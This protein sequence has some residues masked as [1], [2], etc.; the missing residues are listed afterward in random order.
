MSNL[1]KKINVVFEDPRMADFQ[2]KNYESTH[3]ALIHIIEVGKSVHFQAV[4]KHLSFDDA[5]KL[6]SI[7]YLKSIGFSPK[8]LIQLNLRLV[9]NLFTYFRSPIDEITEELAWSI[10]DNYSHFSLLDILLFCDLCKKKKFASEFQHITARGV[11]PDFLEGWLKDYDS[12]KN[13]FIR[14][15]Y[16]ILQQRF[17]KKQRS[18]PA[19][20][21]LENALVDY[22][23]EFQKNSKGETADCILRIAKT[24]VENQSAKLKEEYATLGDSLFDKESAF[25]EFNL[26]KRAEEILENFSQ[27]SPH[28]IIQKALAEVIEIYQIDNVEDLKG[29]FPHFK[30][31]ENDIPSYRNRLAQGLIEIFEK[32]WTV[33]KRK[34]IMAEIPFMTKDYYLKKRAWNWVLRYCDIQLNKAA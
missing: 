15:Q 33:Q 25:I 34:I 30:V 8:K 23:L 28:K 7:K 18:I 29:Q 14:S 6:P 19:S 1:S 32:D 20:K 16:S 22:E 9:G 3:E 5:I 10:M 27:N 31:N 21:F 4:A 17:E 24:S 26:R 11:N 2:K 12:T 13:E